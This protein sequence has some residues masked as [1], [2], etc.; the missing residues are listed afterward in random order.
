MKNRILIL[1]EQLGLENEL[2]EIKKATL[3]K[4]VVNNDNSYQFYIVSSSLLPLKEV[5]ILFSAKKN[6]PYP[7]DFMFET[8]SK[9]S[10]EDILEYST[11][12][13]EGLLKRYPILK[14]L[15]QSKFDFRDNTLKMEVINEIQYNQ[16]KE[17][18]KV[19]DKYF[20]KFG[21]HI[22][23]EAY[24]DKLNDE[25][26]AIQQEMEQANEVVV[27]SAVFE[28][29]N[30]APVEKKEKTFT[31]FNNKKDYFNMRLNEIDGEVRDISVQGY[32]F[33]VYSKKIRTGKTIQS[34][35]ITDYTDSIIVKRFENKGG[36]S[37]EEMNKI[38]KGNCWV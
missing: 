28:K 9:Y 25:Y 6:F 34:L 21:I 37:L 13:F 19:F 36:N 24:I 38:G 11:F 1:L 30:D 31:K 29:K 5:R 33:K 17:L 20:S 23:F 27:D 22:G 15:D 14:T 10:K 7:C 12:I 35:Y 8:I 4:V 3:E 32:V 2:F 16:T 26:Q 18:Y